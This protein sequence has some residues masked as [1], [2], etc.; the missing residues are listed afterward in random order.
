M[1]DVCVPVRVL[2][3]LS[4]GSS[5]VC[6]LL[7]SLAR[8]YTRL[9]LAF[10][11]QDERAGDEMLPMDGY[12]GSARALAEKDACQQQAGVGGLEQPPANRLLGVVTDMWLQVVINDLSCLQRLAETLGVS[13]DDAPS[14][15]TGPL[16]FAYMRKE[17]ED[18]LHSEDGAPPVTAEARGAG[19]TSGP[20]AVAA[21]VVSTAKRIFRGRGRA[22]G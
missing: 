6:L 3:F 9:V 15:S 10:L 20:P 16:G 21:E 12:E 8:C 17:L 5:W 14:G 7:R 11:Q 22:Q 18:I 19:P 13:D 4:Q 1:R 2:V